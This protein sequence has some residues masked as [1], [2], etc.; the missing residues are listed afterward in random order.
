MRRSLLFVLALLLPAVARSQDWRG[1]VTLDVLVED[2]KG[3]NIPGAEILLVY[4]SPD[5]GGSLPSVLTDSDGKASIGGLAAGQWN[6]EVRH[7]GHMSYRAELALAAD[8]KPAVLSAAH[9]MAPGAVSTMKVHFSRGRGGVVPTPQTTAVAPSPN[10][11]IAS[12]AAPAPAPAPVVVSPA[13]PSPAEPK[14]SAG[15]EP[16]KPPVAP[17][18]APPA[19]PVAPPVAAPSVVSPQPVPAPASGPA[20]APAAASAPKPDVPGPRP[21]SAPVPAPAPAPVPPPVVAPPKPVAPPPALSSAPPVV[22]PPAPVAASAAS[23]AAI[24]ARQRLCVECP[25]G[26]AAAWGEAAIEGG[27]TA[28]CPADLGARLAKVALADVAALSASVGAGCR[29]IEVDL[30]AGARFTGFRYESSSAGLTADCLPGRGCP[31]GGCRFP[32]EPV[33][34][35]D[36]NRTILLVA[37]E[38]TAP[39]LRR[40]VVAGYSTYNKKK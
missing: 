18:V 5:G 31:A 21:S 24:P 34:R 12:G 1:P 10:P 38:S 32:I 15:V 13:G 27:A 23:A 36:G 25:A 6:A 26:E 33:L 4:L 7:A 40:A 2:A 16:A 14:A 11:A 37:F 39:D 17:P 29:V 35:Q 3:K 28:G 20:P 8:G 22:A 9:Q 19:A 30:P